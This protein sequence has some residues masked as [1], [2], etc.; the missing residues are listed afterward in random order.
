MGISRNNLESLSTSWWS[1][2][3]RQLRHSQ[4]S[5]ELLGFEIKKLH[6][7]L[8]IAT[9]WCWKGWEL[10]LN[11]F[12]TVWMESV[13]M[14]I[15]EMALLEQTWLMPHLMAKSSTSVLV[16]NAAWCTVF[17]SGWL[18]MW[19]CEIDI[20]ISFLML[21]SVMMRAVRGNEELW[22]TMLSSSCVQVL[23][24]FFLYLF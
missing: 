3:L 8:R 13:M 2:H 24:F 21:A 20:A 9:E 14:I 1:L 10:L 23:S 11:F 22:R 16:M 17:V 7:S 15:L 19:M 5:M 18:A 4:N 6:N 12:F